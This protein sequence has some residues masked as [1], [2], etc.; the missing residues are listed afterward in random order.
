MATVPVGLGIFIKAPTTLKAI[1][2]AILAIRLAVKKP[3]R[4]F[5]LVFIAIFLNA[6]HR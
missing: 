4:S 5:E 2:I 6:C 1:N 3:F